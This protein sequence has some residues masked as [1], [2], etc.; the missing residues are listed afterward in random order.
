MNNF[1]IMRENYNSLKT[2][3]RS[4]L[5]RNPSPNQIK[6]VFLSTP[7]QPRNIIVI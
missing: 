1:N 6:N 3:N 4:P 7:S 5:K 2:L